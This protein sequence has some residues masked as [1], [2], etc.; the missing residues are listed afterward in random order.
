VDKATLE[1]AETWAIGSKLVDADGYPLVLYH[2]TTVQ[3]DEFRPSEVGL[4]GSGIYLT[5]S[6]DDAMEFAADDG[7][8]LEV[9]ARLERPFYTMGNFEP[10]EELDIDSPAIP[11]LQ[12]LYGTEFMKVVAQMDDRGRLGDTVRRDLQ[13]MGH[14]GI[15]VQWP[16]CPGHP[17]VRHIIVYEPRQIRFISHAAKPSPMRQRVCA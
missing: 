4:F 1:A 3:F 17:S 14:D 13:Q 6:R 2:G 16:A 15:V 10:G 5:D 7:P 12:E 9:Y 8:V 11:F